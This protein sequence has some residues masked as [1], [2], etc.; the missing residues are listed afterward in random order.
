MSCEHQTQNE[1]LLAHLKKHHV[2]TRLEAASKPLYIMNLWSRV[3]EL[4]E[5]GHRFDRRPYV[6]KTGK[7][8]LQYWLRTA[9]KARKAA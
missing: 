7:R 9:A 4:E 3:A 8:V 1:R 2:I 6:T 5:Q